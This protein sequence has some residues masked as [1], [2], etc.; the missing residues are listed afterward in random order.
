MIPAAKS[1]YFAQMVLYF[2]ACPWVK[3]DFLLYAA[4]FSDQVLDIITVICFNTCII[5][6]LY[7][8]SEGWTTTTFNL[9]R[10]QLTNTIFIAGGIYLLQLAEQYASE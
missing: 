10:N 9:D 8:L 6:L 3:E 2:E 5:A 4:V 7:L 1:V